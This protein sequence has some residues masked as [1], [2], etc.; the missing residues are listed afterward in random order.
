MP[1]P[2]PA[3]DRGGKKG[4]DPNVTHRLLVTSRLHER[5]G[6]ILIYLATLSQ[7]V[8]AREALRGLV[9]LAVAFALLRFGGLER[10]ALRDG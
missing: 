10:R 2:S 8:T 4:V 9:T 5:L 6:A 3:F 7:P 1:P